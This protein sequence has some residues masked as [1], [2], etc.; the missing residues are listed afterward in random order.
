[1]PRAL[2][3]LICCLFSG[4]VFPADSLEN[5]QLLVDNDNYASAVK[6]GERLLTQHPQQASIMF[7]TAYAYQMNA[8]Q[9]KAVELYEHIIHNKP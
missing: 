7:L 4:M 8:Q 6:S 1:M 9:N 2:L 3:I 5:L